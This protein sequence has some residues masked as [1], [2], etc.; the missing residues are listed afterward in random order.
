LNW[1]N[2]VSFL[3]ASNGFV[4]LVF[5][6]GQLLQ[7]KK[8]AVNYWSFFFF[9]YTAA[10]L[11]L[12]TAVHT[13]I[14]KGDNIEY[15]DAPIMAFAGTLFYFYF[16]RLVNKNYH[17]VWKEQWL[18][19]PPILFIITGLILWFNSPVVG[20]SIATLLSEI[21]IIWVLFCCTRLLVSLFRQYK[22]QYLYHKIRP[23]FVILII[24]VV[25]FLA[26]LFF[27]PMLVQIN[28]GP[29]FLIE[30]LFLLAVYFYHLRHPELLISI[31]RE[32]PP[33][34][35]D[36]KSKIVGLDV[37]KTI[38]RLEQ[39][40]EQQKPYLQDNL[41]L[42]ELADMIGLSIHQ[43]SEILNRKMGTNFKTYINHF[44][45]ADAQG[46]LREQPEASILDVAFTCGFR[47]K[48]AFNRIFREETGMTP[49]EYR[50]K[51]VEDGTAQKAAQSPSSDHCTQ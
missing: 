36:G 26:V 16:V 17:F 37:K 25:I 34:Q 15:F 20:D 40:M 27:L 28:T 47:S 33:S 48:S 50:R 42:L 4:F 22:E 9:E 44:R 8:K 1:S 51:N 14:L 7:R 13:G 24:C 18:F 31:D 3:V 19:L 23:S 43:L 49:T 5:G 2:W 38:D 30:T 45:V 39:I 10:V 6:I 29:F 35:Q 21:S 46:I 41:S 12:T 11:L 32:S